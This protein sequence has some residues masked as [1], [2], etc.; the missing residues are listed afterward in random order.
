MGRGNREKRDVFANVLGN[1]RGVSSVSDVELQYCVCA[2]V[3]DALSLEKEGVAY[4]GYGEDGLDIF[5][6]K[7]VSE[8]NANERFWETCSF[9]GQKVRIVRT[10]LDEAT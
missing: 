3:G 2:E 10:Y 1:R 7:A 6:V 4:I 5:H 8:Q 9:F